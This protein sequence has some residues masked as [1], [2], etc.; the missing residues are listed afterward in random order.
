[1]KGLCMIAV[2]LNHV[3]GL[4][5]FWRL[6]YPF[7]LA[8]F[9]FV[10]G[11]TFSLRDSFAK[12]LRRKSCTLLL[13]VLCF[14]FINAC[15]SYYVKGGEFLSRIRDLVFQRP[16][17]WD[18]LWFV[19]CLYVS[20]IIFY[21]VVR[22]VSVLKYRFILCVI[23][24]IG[25]YVFVQIHP[26]AL[27]WHIEN[28]FIFLPFVCVG[29]IIKIY[30][31]KNSTFFCVDIQRILSFFMLSLSYV[32]IVLIFKNYPIDVHLHQYGKFLVF[33][34]SALIGVSVIFIL[35]LLFESHHAFILLRFLCFI[36][37]NTL[38]YY[39]FQSKIISSLNVIGERMMIL[40]LHPYLKGL[41]Y[42]LV[43]CLIL[44]VP[45]L[46]VN[47]FAPF[48]IGRP[49]QKRINKVKGI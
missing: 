44:I 36:G 48:L 13:P 19:A 11:Y 42:C 35:S 32:C 34:L 46:I 45:S 22:M 8:G 25:G 28:A 41:T 21:F 18:D 4:E 2:I 40:S 30:S 6:T 29:H 49:F 16:G 14:G 43:C 12:F 9:F 15:L 33:M 47:R 38:V 7:E 31:L 10:A 1:M 20:E 39:A 27:P 17:S 26:I 5:F 37:A 3:S 24:S 23:L